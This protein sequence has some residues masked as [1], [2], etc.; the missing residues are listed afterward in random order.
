MPS[1]PRGS[2]N[3]AGD[4]RGPPDRIDRTPEPVRDQVVEDLGADRAPF[5]R[6]TDHR[7]RAGPE[8][9]LESF[10]ARSSRD[11]RVPCFIQIELMNASPSAHGGVPLTRAMDM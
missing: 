7:D 3:F 11:L 4:L 6:R 1:M 10:G 2:R 5:T 9:G 8:Q